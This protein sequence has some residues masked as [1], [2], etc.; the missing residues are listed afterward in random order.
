M[1]EVD[2]AVALGRMDTMLNM[3]VVVV[4]QVEM[5]VLA[6]M[7]VAP[8]LVLAQE[9]VV[10]ATLPLTEGMVDNGVIMAQGVEVLEALVQ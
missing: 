4:P 10:E 5:L 6:V 1:P 9:E 2:G 8:Y 3:A 7:V